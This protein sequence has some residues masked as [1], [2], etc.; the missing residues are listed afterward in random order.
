VAAVRRHQHRPRADGPQANIVEL[1]VSGPGGQINGLNLRLYQPQARRWSSTFTNL[2]DGMPAPSVH[3]GFH[4][5]VGEFYGDDH[6][7][8]RQV[9]V[10]F[11]I[12]RQGPD[13]ARF[14]QAFF[15]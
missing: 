8:G 4:H 12:H 1:R 10:R 6:L 7:A 13:R 2:R 5:G 3:G 11:L 14:E 9:K 15:R